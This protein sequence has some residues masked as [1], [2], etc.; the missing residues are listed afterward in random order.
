MDALGFGNAVKVLG[1]G[2]ASKEDKIDLGVGI[3]LN[4]KVGNFVEKGESIFT[5]FHSNVGLED[6]ITYSTNAVEVS[7]D[8]VRAEK[9]ILEII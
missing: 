5:I 8:R 7:K 6:A 4:K 2:R 9:L 1:G 3:I